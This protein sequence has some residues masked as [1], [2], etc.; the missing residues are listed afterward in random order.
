M[1]GTDTRIHSMQGTF[2]RSTRDRMGFSE[3]S[4]LSDR[5]ANLTR[6]QAA[7]DGQSIPPM[8]QSYELSQIDPY[9]VPTREAPPV[10]LPSQPATSQ[11][12]PRR[13]SH[14]TTSP[15]EQPTL[16]L[17]GID[18]GPD[19]IPPFVNNVDETPSIPPIV[20]LES[21]QDANR[22]IE[23]ERLWDARAV[24]SQRT[25]D[26]LN[27]IINFWSSFGRFVTGEENP[28]RQYDD[29]YNWGNESDNVF[30][31]SIIGVGVGASRF[32]RGIVTSFAQL[33]DLIRNLPWETLRLSNSDDY[34][35]TLELLQSI[36]ESELEDP[37]MSREILNGIGEFFNHIGNRFVRAIEYAEN[38][39]NVESSAQIT[40]GTLEIIDLIDTVE[41]A[42]S[43][44]RRTPQTIRRL[45]DLRAARLKLVEAAVI[46][47][48]IREEGVLGRH[49]DNLDDVNFSISPFGGGINMPTTRRPHRR[50]LPDESESRI[51]DADRS[52]E[53]EIIQTRNYRS[54]ILNLRNVIRNRRQREMSHILNAQQSLRMGYFQRG[55]E[56]LFRERMI[57]V[58]TNSNLSSPHKFIDFIDPNT[59]RFTNINFHLNIIPGG[60]QDFLTLQAGHMDDFSTGRRQRFGFQRAYDNIREGNEAG[61]S[62]IPILER[63]SIIIDDVVIERNTA[64]FMVGEGVLTRNEVRTAQHSIGWDPLQWDVREG[65]I[66]GELIWREIPTLVPTPSRRY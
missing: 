55:A 16:N 63:T 38:G 35:Q 23:E 25:R 45:T 13:P 18:R 5:V 52:R 2:D 17:R 37:A 8:R 20:Y 12:R 28:M 14:Q 31:G 60:H 41:G 24:Q 46:L 61:R 58:I 32:I 1:S 49:I 10:T 50:R 33:Y 36:A 47:R 30:Q 11:S 59:G 64:S 54:Y 27:S 53:L 65:S 66:P 9:A 40:E 3:R 43:L 48:M 42:L 4:R 15:I 44:A 39:N 51:P 62:G 6:R 26:E 34:I 29:I 21:I 56:I 22:R 7:L 19:I 57:D